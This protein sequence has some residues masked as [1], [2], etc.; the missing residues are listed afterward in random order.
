VR[1]QRGDAVRA[2]LAALGLGE[3]D[4]ADAVHWARADSAAPKAAPPATRAASRSRAGK[5][6][7][8]RKEAR[9]RGRRSRG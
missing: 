8:G 1:I 5:R 7:T 2:K 6:A 4:R 3:A 9:G